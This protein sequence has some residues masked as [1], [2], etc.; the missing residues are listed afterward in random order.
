MV[1]IDSDEPECVLFAH[2]LN[3]IVVC[4]RVNSLSL[5]LKLSS[6]TSQTHKCLFSPCIKL[7]CHEGTSGHVSSH[8]G[9]LAHAT[10]A[11]AVMYQAIK[12]V[13]PIPVSP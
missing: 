12:A 4:I 6:K 2:E 1:Q 11:P 7:L 5:S 8:Q 9:C 3:F 13:S 10:K